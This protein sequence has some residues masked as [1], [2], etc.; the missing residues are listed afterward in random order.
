MP[1]ADVPKGSP[2]DWLRRARSDLALAKSTPAGGDV[3]PESLCFHAQQSVEKAIKAV[4]VFSGV[5]FPR[6]HNIGT[7]LELLPP[8]TPRNIALGE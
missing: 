5:P 8:G 3:L 7:L 2:T 6:T 1:S 4:L